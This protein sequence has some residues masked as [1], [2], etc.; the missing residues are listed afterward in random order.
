MQLHTLYKWNVM[1]LAIHYFGKSHST[2]AVQFSGTIHSTKLSGKFR[3]KTEWISLI[4][5]EKF[6]RKEV[7]LSRWD[8]SNRNWPFLLTFLTHFES[9]YLAVRYLP[10]V[11]LVPPCV[12]T[13]VTQCMFWLF[14]FSN[15]RTLARKFWLNGSC[16]KSYK[17]SEVI[18]T[19]VVL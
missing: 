10:S 8:W 16:P 11:L 1:K 3:S 2:W 13:T 4:Q 12:V 6:R 15:F 17:F 9:K 14:F 18:L 7:H 5:T 19:L